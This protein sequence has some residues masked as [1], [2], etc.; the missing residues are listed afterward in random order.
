MD[1]PTPPIATALVQSLG[2]AAQ[3]KREPLSPIAQEIRRLLQNPTSIGAALALREIFDP[4]LA[5]RKR[6]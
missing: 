5:L 6:K 2:E 3:V 4:P 1:L